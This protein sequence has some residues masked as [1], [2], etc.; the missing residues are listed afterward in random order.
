MQFSIKKPTI[1]NVLKSNSLIRGA[2]L[3]DISE[4]EVC[5]NEVCENQV[6]ENQEILI[7]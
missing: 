2:T 5:K 4:N 1:L 6:S 7:E 3:S